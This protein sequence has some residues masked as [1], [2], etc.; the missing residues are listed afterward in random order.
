MASKEEELNRLAYEAQNLE[1]QLQEMQRQLQ[2]AQL[3]VNEMNSTSASLEGLKELKEDTYF[4]LGSGAFI[5]GTAAENKYILIDV[6]AGVFM[7]KP[8][9]EAREL[10]LKRR[11]KLEKG[12]EALKANLTQGLKRLQEINQLADD[13]QQ[14]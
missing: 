3:L 5:K 2:Q 8:I 6:G 14:Q 1:A 12:I 7:E 13:L 9:G 4:Q 10:I 11:E